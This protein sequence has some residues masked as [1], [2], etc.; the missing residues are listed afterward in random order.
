MEK[1]NKDQAKVELEFLR[2]KTKL[3]G[4]KIIL[5]EAARVEFIEA[6]DKLVKANE[7]LLAARMLT[8]KEWEDTKTGK[9]SYI[10][11]SRSRQ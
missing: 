3:M 5:H 9:K 7:D 2:H 10:F 6:K 8:Q 1:N 4:E 11:P